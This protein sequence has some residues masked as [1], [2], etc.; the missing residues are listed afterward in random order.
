MF[1]NKSNITDWVVVTYENLSQTVVGGVRA[2]KFREFLRGKNKKVTLITREKSFP[3]DIQIGEFPIPKLIIRGIN[4]FFVDPAFMWVIRVYQ[5]V[6]KKRDFILFT[7]SPPHGIHLL[8]CLFKF[9]RRDDVHW[10]ADFRDPFTDNILYKP[11]L[12]KRFVDKIYENIIYKYADTLVFNTDTYLVDFVKKHPGLRSKA[13]VIR[14]GFDASVNGKEKKAWTKFIYSGG[15]YKGLAIQGIHRFLE[16]LSNYNKG[17]RCDVIGEEFYDEDEK[18]YL[19]DYLGRVDQDRVLPIISEYVYGLIFLPK[20]N[21]TTGRVPQKFYDY[22]GAGIIPV[23]INPSREMKAIMKKLRIGIVIYEESD[24]NKIYLNFVKRKSN[25]D[26]H[27]DA[28]M[29]Y[30]RTH[31]FSKLLYDLGN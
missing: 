15:N 24:F 31:Q 13:I 30:S 6:R 4:F 29:E 26:F 3:D 16:L 19:L 28:I 18:Y 22:L 23:C 2:F 27:R 14:N 10:I 1:S 8:G 25:I 12:S 7:T 17:I 21:I 9:A 5:H 20:A 11:F